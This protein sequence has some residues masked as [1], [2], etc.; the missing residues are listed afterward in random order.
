MSPTAGNDWNAE[1]RFEVRV[2]V[3][4]RDSG[5]VGLA[6]EAQKSES[7][8]QSTWCAREHCVKGLASGFRVRVK[9]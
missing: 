8:T 7:F 3:G 4:V 9:G 1:S 2:Q 5:H 6:R